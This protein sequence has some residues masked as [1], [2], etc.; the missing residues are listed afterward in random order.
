MDAPT[1]EQP[2]DVL[3]AAN[4]LHRVSVERLLPH[5]PPVTCVFPSARARE[6]FYATFSFVSRCH[7]VGVCGSRPRERPY[8][9]TCVYV[10]GTPLPPR[11]F[12][13]PDDDDGSGERRSALLFDSRLF[14]SS[15]AVRADALAR[16]SPSPSSS[17]SP[18][19]SLHYVLSRVSSSSPSSAFLTVSLAMQP[20]RFRLLLSSSAAARHTLG[21]SHTS[22]HSSPRRVAEKHQSERA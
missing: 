10:R 14:E 21:L 5:R 2:M 9:C 8:V 17:L 3:G 12:V 7:A 22:P 19:L 20:A 6:P 13:H 1:G 4:T 11:P 15:S 16:V 18:F